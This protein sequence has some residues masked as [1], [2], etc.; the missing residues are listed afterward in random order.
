M[1]RLCQRPRWAL[2][3]ALVFETVVFVAGQR[4]FIAADRLWYASIA[5]ALS[6]DP[7]SVLADTHPC[8]MRIG[9]TLPLALLYRLFGVSPLITNLLALIAGLG[10]TLVVYAAAPTPRAKTFAML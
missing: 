3:C 2:V 5:H 9:L 10:V 8:A 4:D 1:D 7:A 6:V